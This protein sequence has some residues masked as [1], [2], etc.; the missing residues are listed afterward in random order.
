MGENTTIKQI[1][2]LRHEILR[3]IHS[4]NIAKIKGNKEHVQYS[5]KEWPALSNVNLHCD[6]F[7]EKNFG[8]N[9]QIDVASIINEQI[10]KQLIELMPNP[11]YPSV[12]YESLVKLTE[13][14]EKTVGN[15]NM[16]PFQQEILKQIA[17]AN[18]IGQISLEATQRSEKSA[19][20]W[21]LLSAGA[22]I[23]SALIAALDLIIRTY[24][25]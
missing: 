1:E 8:R 2:A 10:Q 15:I 6:D 5:E 19:K 13:E 23:L 21:F 14:G 7:I 11:S 9:I 12:S 17:E 16:P 22:A 18:R 3:Y 24:I 25:Q 4:F 20:K